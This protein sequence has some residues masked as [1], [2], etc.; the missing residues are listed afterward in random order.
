MDGWKV[1][2]PNIA[3][4]AGAGDY[5]SVVTVLRCTGNYRSDKVPDYLIMQLYL[6]FLVPEA[7][8]S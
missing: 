3:S 6:F 7:N 5:T 4:N 2:M 8:D 1:K